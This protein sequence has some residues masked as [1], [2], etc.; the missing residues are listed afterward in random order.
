V[1]TVDAVPGPA[2]GPVQSPVNLGDLLLARIQDLTERGARNYDGP[3]LQFVGALLERAA[4]LADRTGLAAQHLRQ[5]GAARRDELEQRFAADQA[6]ARSALGQLE[7]CGV[8]RK[9][10]EQLLDEGDARAVLRAR[11]ALHELAAR[12]RN[13]TPRLTPTIRRDQRTSWRLAGAAAMRAARSRAAKRAVHD[14]LTSRYRARRAELATAMEL[15]SAHQDLPESPG[16][17]NGQTVALQLLRTLAELSPLYAHSLLERVRE[18]A[19]LQPLAQLA[20]QQGKAARPT[21]A[22]GQRPERKR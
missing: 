2:D 5:R 17:Y 19:A 12:G 3:G 22:P 9:R 7:A 13:G 8:H 21:G 16:P 11:R 14:A 18:L 6:L 4:R 1:S 20:A 15:A 10:A